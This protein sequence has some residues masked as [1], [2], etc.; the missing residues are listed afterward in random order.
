MRAASVGSLFLAVVSAGASAGNINTTYQPAAHAY[1][2]EYALCDTGEKDAADFA[3]QPS[4]EV[5]GS[6]CWSRVYSYAP[7]DYTL[8]AADFEREEC[9]SIPML[10]SSID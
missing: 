8:A 1:V 5:S 4:T 10:S 9:H 7:Y 2:A 3:A 6:A